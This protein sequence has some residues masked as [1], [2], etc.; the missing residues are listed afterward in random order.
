MRLR[1]SEE[2]FQETFLPQSPEQPAGFFKKETK[3]ARLVRCVCR[4]VWRLAVTVA[5]SAVV[6]SLE[7][8][9]C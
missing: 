6:T 8:M 1:A 2:L 9:Q 3:K 4:S 7:K 5:H